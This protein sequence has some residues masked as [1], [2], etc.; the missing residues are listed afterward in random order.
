MNDNTPLTPQ[1]V[2][3]M[4][5]IS[6]S[7]VYE[8]IKQNKI[9]SYK[10]GKKLRIDLKDVE[11]YKNKTKSQVNN[12]AYPAVENK[13]SNEIIGSVEG[14]ILQSVAI[15]N[16]NSD[17]FHPF[18]IC[19]QDLL[20]DVLSRYLQIHP[21]GVT[22]LRSYQGSY[23]SLYSLYNGDANIATAHMWDAK[24]GKYNF[25]YVDKMLPG[26]SSVLVNL[27][28]RQQGFY[29]YKGNPKNI[30]S[31]DDLRRSDISIINREK[32]SGTRI[33]L[34]ERLKSMGIPP[35]S[36]PG[37]NREGL[38]HLALASAVARGEADYGIGI[39][40][41]ANQVNSIEF[42]PLQTEQYD[43]II[44]KEDINTPVMQAVISILNST[45]F[46]NEISGLGGYDITDMGRIVG[47]T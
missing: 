17:K 33:L 7:T 13:F 42:I 32:G 40:K 36:V 18:I 30:S 25:A 44:K 15:N 47:E 45:E 12:S 4:L 16:T 8:M 20:L 27:A 46:R 28:Y 38:S 41:V 29:V 35:Q 9:N 39:E 26:T 14:N 19:G 24:T 37:Y 31:W 22:N 23:N 5:K 3:E 21:N 34:D 11:G 2:A 10:V 6:K 43:M 1:E